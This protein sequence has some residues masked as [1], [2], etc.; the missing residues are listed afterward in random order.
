MTFD[1]L[2]FLKKKKKTAFLT[3]FHICLIKVVF[4][5]EIIFYFENAF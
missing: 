3:I 2:V 4:D 5:I 1:T